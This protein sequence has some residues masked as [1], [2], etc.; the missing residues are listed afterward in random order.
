MAD[1]RASRYVLFG[2]DV[3]H[4]HEGT[5]A[6]VQSLPTS[7]GLLLGALGHKNMG[8]ISKVRRKLEI[9]HQAY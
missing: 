5:F 6:L 8:Q 3:S 9:S 7:A 2:Q 4:G 1:E